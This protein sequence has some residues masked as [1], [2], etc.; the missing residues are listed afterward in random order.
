MTDDIQNDEQKA[1]G[2]IGMNEEKSNSELDKCQKNATNI[3]MDGNGR[4]RI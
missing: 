3:L 4:R 2:E 1:D